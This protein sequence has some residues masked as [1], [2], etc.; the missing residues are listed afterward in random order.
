MWGG[1]WQDYGWRPTLLQLIYFIS[2][3][4]FYDNETSAERSVNYAG[5]DIA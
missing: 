3:S 2:M 1:G 5:F 4:F